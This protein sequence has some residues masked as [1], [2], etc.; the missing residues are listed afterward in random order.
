VWERATEAKAGQQPVG[1]ELAVLKE[2]SAIYAAATAQ[3]Q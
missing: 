1:D 2:L 3:D